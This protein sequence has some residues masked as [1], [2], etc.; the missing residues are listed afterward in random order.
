ME[1]TC[2]NVHEEN[3]TIEGPSESGLAP[4]LN[5]LPPVELNKLSEVYEK[6]FEDVTESLKRTVNASMFNED[7]DAPVERQSQPGRFQV[8]WVEIHSEQVLRS[9]STCHLL[10][11]LALLHD[12]HFPDL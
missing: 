12:A 4:V 8:K 10:A 7:A 2:L 9:P 6:S 5:M 3:E 11:Q 1:V